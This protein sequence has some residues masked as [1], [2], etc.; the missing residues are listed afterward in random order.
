M[1]HAIKK[2]RLLFAF[3]FHGLVGAA[4]ADETHISWIAQ[5]A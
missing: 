3:L 4:I 1:G 2:I 5:A